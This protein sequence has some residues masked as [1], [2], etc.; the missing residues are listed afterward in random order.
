MEAA[1]TAALQ[2]V[3]GDF[4]D[5]KADLTWS[6]N[7]NSVQDRKIFRAGIVINPYTDASCSGWEGHANQQAMSGFWSTEEKQLLKAIFLNLQT[8]RH[9]LKGKHIK[10]FCDNTR[11]SLEAHMTIGVPS[12]RVSLQ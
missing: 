1:K 7:N 6:L 10:V 11:P 12:I 8:L 3:K 9:E 4:N 2:E 5:M